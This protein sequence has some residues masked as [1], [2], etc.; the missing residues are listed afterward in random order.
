MLS[1]RPTAHWW[2]RPGC[3]GGH[4]VDS[5]DTTMTMQFSAQTSELGIILRQTDYYQF[6]S[7]KVLPREINF[8][9]Y[10]LLLTYFDAV[11]LQE[12]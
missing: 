10:E 6:K 5:S 4:L 3:L 12:V 8:C 2:S 1:T 11:K 9:Y 7:S